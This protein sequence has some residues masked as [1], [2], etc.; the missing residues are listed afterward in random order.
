MSDKK[1]CASCGRPIEG[2]PLVVPTANNDVNNQFHAS[3]SE[4][5]GARK[6][7]GAKIGMINSRKRQAEFQRDAMGWKYE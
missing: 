3:P 2:T 4:C 1:N 6:V 5:S 7:S